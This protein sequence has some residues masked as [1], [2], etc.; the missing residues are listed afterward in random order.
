MSKTEAKK[1]DKMMFALTA[2]I[3]DARRAGA[4]TAKLEAE[5]AKLYEARWA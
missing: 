3:A 5:L 1:T 4:D 2:Q